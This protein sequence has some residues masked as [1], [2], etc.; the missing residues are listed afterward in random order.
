MNLH[1]L[2][3]CFK[4]G[5]IHMHFWCGFIAGGGIGMILGITGMCVYALCVAGN[6]EDRRREKD[7]GEE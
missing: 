4:K 3:W 2:N 1:I 5:V 6:K 7:E